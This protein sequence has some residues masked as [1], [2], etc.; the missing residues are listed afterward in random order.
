[1][2]GG[3]V[4]QIGDVEE[5]RNGFLIGIAGDEI[6]FTVEIQ[7]SRLQTGKGTDVNKVIIVLST[8]ISVSLVDFFPIG[9]SALAVI[10]I[11]LDIGGAVVFNIDRRQ[12][13]IPIPIVVTGCDLDGSMIIL[14]GKSPVASLLIVVLYL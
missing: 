14:E 9:K 4:R 12:V 11:D 8:D 5:K 2:K 1:M 6:G 13:L 3:I 7:I 10:A